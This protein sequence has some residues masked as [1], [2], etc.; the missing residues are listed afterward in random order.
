MMPKTQSLEELLQLARED[1]NRNQ[2]STAEKNLEQAILLNNQSPEAFHLLGNVYSKRGKFKKAILA[3]KK[4][5]LLDP[6]H[7]EAAI[8]LSSLQ[9]DVGNYKEAAMV[10]QNA[11]K[12]LENT[13]PGFDPRINQGL[14]KSHFNLGMAYMKYERFLEAHH[15]F[16]KAFNLEPENI[17]SAI[18]M[19]RCLSKTGNKEGAL[20]LLKKALETQ[21]KHV[22]AKIQLGIL[23]HSLRKLKEAYREWKEALLL[24]PENKSAQMY[25]S[26]F[27]YEITQSGSHVQAETI[28]Y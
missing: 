7:T 21:P 20:S 14:A 6:A 27:D 26:M 1:I 13:Q 3:F 15:E 9:N 4:A 22:E 8:A 2:I 11:R 19:A 10:Y 16:S 17:V 24:D 25:L 5:L 28:S 18:Q 23:Y 12:R